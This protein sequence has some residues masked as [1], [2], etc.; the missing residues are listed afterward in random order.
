MTNQIDVH[1][2]GRR[3]RHLAALI[4]RLGAA[5]TGAS[6]R[7]AQPF[8]HVV[9]DDVLP[10]DVFEHAAAEFPPI[11]DPIWNGY[12]HV[13][14]TKYANAEPARWGPALRSITGSLQSDDFVAALGALTG[15]PD[16]VADPEMDG[17]GLHQ[18][19]RGGHLNIHTDFTT[20]H[21]NRWLCRRVNLLLYLNESWSDEWGGALELWDA[22]VRR[23]VRRVEPLGNR[24]LIFT[25]SGVSAYHGHPDPLQSPEG[26]A[27][28][29]LALYYFTHEKRP[30]RR[31]T[32]YRARPGDGLRRVPIWIDRQTL[33][34]YDAAKRRFR[35]SDR[36][37][38]RVMNGVDRLRRH[39][40]G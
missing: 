19:L 8:P 34:A 30:V 20:H 31:A 28:R 32:I 16:L 6:Y 40:P 26:V 24:M 18:T 25:T 21:R 13:N 37:V 17:G 9:I 14:E 1:Q 15:F 22:S 4:A 35:I 3:E 10:P 11:D 36:A 23:C 12:V 27:R 33:A 39:K 7:E 29:S 2:P 5:E 38:H